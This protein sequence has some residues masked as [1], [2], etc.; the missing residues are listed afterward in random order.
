[1]LTT[2]VRAALL[3]ATLILCLSAAAQQPAAAT[4]PAT[5]ASQKK[6]V[7]PTRVEDGDVHL[8]MDGELDEPVWQQAA[9]I[10]GFT[11]TDPDLGK[12]VSEKTEALIFYDSQNIYF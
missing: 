6:T 4:N 1:M 10:D 5:P 3:G 9:V 7:A 11:Q 12:P 2:A 8:R